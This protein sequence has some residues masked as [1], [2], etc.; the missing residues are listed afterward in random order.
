[1]AQDGILRP[2]VLV[3]CSGVSLQ[4]G[5]SMRVIVA[6]DGILRPLVLVRCSGVSLKSGISMRVIVAQDGILRRLLLGLKRQCADS[7][8]H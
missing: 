8:R 3:R 5:I 7:H 1:V 2:P 4:S 6:Q